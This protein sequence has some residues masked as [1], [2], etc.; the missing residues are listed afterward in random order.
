MVTEC[1]SARC[2]IIWKGRIL[3]PRLGGNGKRW[4]TKRIL[5]FLQGSGASAGRAGC[6]AHD[7]CTP[8]SKVV[9]STFSIGAHFK[10]SINM[11]PPRLW[12]ISASKNALQ[13]CLWPALLHSIGAEVKNFA[14]SGLRL[15]PE[16]RHQVTPNRPRRSTRASFRRL[17]TPGKQSGYRSCSAEDALPCCRHSPAYCFYASVPN[18]ILSSEASGV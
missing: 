8:R 1:R 2:R 9:P 11:R 5:I 7:V 15:F 18:F 10:P 13:P 16:C 14:L 3:P 17:L 6:S 12:A 4:Q